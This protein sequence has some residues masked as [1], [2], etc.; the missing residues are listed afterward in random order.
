MIDHANSLATGANLPR[1][2][3]SS[4]AGIEVPVAP[5]SE[6]RRIAAILDQADGLRQ[7]RHSLI[8]LDHLVTSTFI[9]EFG[10]FEE[11]PSRWPVTPFQ[12]SSPIPNLVS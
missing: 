2:S 6:Q 11:K 1:L 3:P 5:V 4:L 12:S 9:G 10:N 8:Q 7:R